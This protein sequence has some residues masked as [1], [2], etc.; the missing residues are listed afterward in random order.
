MAKTNTVAAL[1]IGTSS[2]K[3]LVGQKE[4]GSSEINVLAKSEMPYFIGVRKGEIYDPKTLGETLSLLKGNIQRSSGIN[5]KKVVVNVGGPHLFILPSQGLV[6]VSRADQKISQGDIQRVLQASRA[7]NLPLNKEI[8]DVYPRE[9]IVDGEGGIKDPLGLQ[10]IRL[11]AK[12]LLICVFSPVLENLETALYNAGLEIEEIFPSPLA[13]SR[14]VLT[15]EQ[16]ELGAAAVDIG[17]GTTSL[18]IFSEGALQE[19]IVFPIGSANITNDIAIGLRTEIAVAEKIKREFGSFGLSSKKRKNK[20]GKIEIPEKELS[21]SEKYLKDIIKSRISEIF[22]QVSKVLKKTSKETVL[23]GGVILTGGGSLLPGI[24]K[25]AK[26]KLIPS[27]DSPSFSTCAGLLLSAFDSQEIEGERIAG[28][29][30]KNKIKK[31]FK[32]FLP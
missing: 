11:E 5:I 31:V 25:F 6:S 22:S 24:V 26:D 12:V 10:G 28:E 7:V 13:S 3:L 20:G 9:F 4:K 8:L 1:D 18:S 21:F 17:A 14:A 2:V 30:I 32:M 19:F 16:K 27:V 29:G 15:E 23:P